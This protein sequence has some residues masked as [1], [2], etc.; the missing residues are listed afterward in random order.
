[1]VCDLTNEDTYHGTSG[2]TERMLAS[3]SKD[4]TQSVKHF[5]S[6]A[7]SHGDASLVESQNSD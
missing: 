1:M 7:S 6:M 4:P 5:W 2:N 3:D